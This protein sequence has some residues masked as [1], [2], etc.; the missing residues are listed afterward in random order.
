M[1][2]ARSFNLRLASELL[3]V[4]PAAVS[5]AAMRRPSSGTMTSVSGNDAV[6]PSPRTAA[7][8]PAIAVSAA[9]AYDAFR[10]GLHQLGYVEGRNISVEYRYADGSLDR[11]P[12]LAEELVRLNPSVIVS[13]PMPANLAVRKAT[14]TIPIVM[15]NGADPVRF[16]LVGRLRGQDSKGR[17]TR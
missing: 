10:V 12:A 16:G 13:A 5:N 3:G 11:L 9:A 4:K 1:R 14:S 15:A 7:F 8:Q 17:E 6:S 2:T